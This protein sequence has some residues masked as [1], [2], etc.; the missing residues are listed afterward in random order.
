MSAPYESAVT[1]VFSFFSELVTDDDLKAKL[2]FEEAK[3]RFALDQILLTTQTTPKVDAAVKV[4]MA[5]RDIVIP[6]FRPLGAA[7]MTAF[8]AYCMMNGIELSE[9]IQY[10]LF[11]APIGYGVSRHVDKKEQQ[12]T[13]RAKS[14]V[15][16][17]DF[18]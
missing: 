12:K 9:P 14:R 16:D 1:S 10:L 3:L 8:G 18:E 15:I 7:C 17:E 11:G 6:M 13:I 2:V 5:L 4:L